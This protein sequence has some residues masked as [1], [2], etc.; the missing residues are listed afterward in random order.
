[1]KE[2]T[3]K[4]LGLDDGDNYLKMISETLDLG[5]FDEILNGNKEDE[6]YNNKKI[7]DIKDKV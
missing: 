2:K 5:E 1:M 6:E 4:D 3:L 7:K